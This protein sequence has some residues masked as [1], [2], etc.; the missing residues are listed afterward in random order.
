MK[1]VL[2]A[3]RFLSGITAAGL[4]ALFCLCPLSAA[5]DNESESP[6]TEISDAAGLAAIASAAVLMEMVSA[7]RLR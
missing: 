4:L 3:K 2:S 7:P 5:A 1:H 6:Y